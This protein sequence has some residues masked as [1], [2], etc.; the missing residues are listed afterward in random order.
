MR[1][2]GTDQLCFDFVSTNQPL[3]VK[4]GGDPRRC[5]RAE[6][7]Y[8]LCGVPSASPTLPLERSCESTDQAALSGGGK[9]NLWIR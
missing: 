4:P 5:S 1:E 8:K 3:S 2:A 9:G 6:L 7:V